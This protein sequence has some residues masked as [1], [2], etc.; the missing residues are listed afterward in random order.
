MSYECEQRIKRLANF[1]KVGNK[2]SQIE[3]K[4]NGMRFFA[5]VQ[6]AENEVL[7]WR[8]DV[9][10]EGYNVHIELMLNTSQD[11]ILK[12]V[13]VQTDLSSYLD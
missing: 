5:Y 3:F 1:N 11:A 10:S 7:E 6:D 2:T 9:K 4:S 12:K 13:F 8:Y